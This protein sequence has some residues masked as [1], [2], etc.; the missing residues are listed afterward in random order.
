MVKPLALT[1]IKMFKIEVGLRGQIDLFLGENI[2][3]LLC[4]ITLIHTSF[5]RTKL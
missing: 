3:L 1:Y 4:N 2:F 5:P